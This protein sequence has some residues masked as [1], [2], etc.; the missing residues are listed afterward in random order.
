MMKMGMWYSLKPITLPKAIAVGMAAGIVRSSM[1][2]F[3]SP[4]GR[5]WLKRNKK[6][7]QQNRKLP[8]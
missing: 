8:V 3:L 6:L 2:L 1:S 5:S 4:A 7:P